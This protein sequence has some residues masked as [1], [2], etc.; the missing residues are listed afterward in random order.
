M[1]GDISF[2][3]FNSD[4]H[5]KSFAHIIKEREKMIS[6]AVEYLKTK[7]SIKDDRFL[8]ELVTRILRKITVTDTREKHYPVWDEDLNC[9]LCGK[10]IFDSIHLFDLKVNSNLPD[11]EFSRIEQKLKKEFEIPD[12]NWDEL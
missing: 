3:D 8:K 11:D 7:V 9:A 10:G 2:R 1:I 4:L 12:V 6:D 5:K